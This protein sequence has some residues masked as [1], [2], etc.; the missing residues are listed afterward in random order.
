LMRDR[1]RAALEY[2]AASKKKGGL[3]HRRDLQLDAIVES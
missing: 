3:P 1:F 2:E